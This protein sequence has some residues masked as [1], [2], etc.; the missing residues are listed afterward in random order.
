M[1]R[2][3]LSRKRSALSSETWG[4]ITPWMRT[5]LSCWKRFSSR[6]S[7]EVRRV[8]KVESGTSLP[9]GPVTW[10]SASWSGVSRSL[11]LTWGMTL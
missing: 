1:T 5:A 6:G 9:A 11:R 2:A 4:G 7:V 8:A 3:S 10:I